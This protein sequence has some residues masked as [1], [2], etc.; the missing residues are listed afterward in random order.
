MD[1]LLEPEDALFAQR[2][3]A[4]PW[5]DLGR[6]WTL[7]VV[8]LFSKLVLTVLN[9]FAVAPAELAE[10]R[11]HAAERAPQRGLI[12]VCNHTR[13]GGSGGACGCCC[14]LLDVP[15]STC[16]TAPAAAPPPRCLQHHGRPAALLCHA[17]R[18]VLLPG[19]LAGAGRLPGCAA[20]SA[21]LPASVGVRFVCR[22][23][24]AGQGS[25]PPTTLPARCAWRAGHAPCARLTSPCSALAT[26]AQEHR[27]LGNR[28]SLCAQEICYR[29]PLLGAFFQ[30]GK[31]LPIQVWA[32][33]AAAGA[34]GLRLPK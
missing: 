16:H 14:G 20:E 6:S 29:N 21:R 24:R 10:F 25:V 5:G 17:A 30:S 33:A 4:A 31:T 27:H 12:T 23:G 9:D 28:W 13:C 15:G 34:A 3:L 1:S 26:R 8:S 18:L 7:G 22:Q 2:A 19:G 32:A 11:R